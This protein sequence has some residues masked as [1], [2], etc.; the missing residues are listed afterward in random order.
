MST[1][2]RRHRLG[3]DFNLGGEQAEADPLLDRVFVEWTGYQ[4]VES[5]MNPRCFLIGRTGSGKSAVLQRLEEVHPRRVIRINPED[6]S[7]PYIVDLGVIRSLDALNVHLD[8]LFIALWK[9]VPLVEIIRHRYSVDS[10]TKK[11]TVLQSLKDSFSR[12]PS[13]QA[14]LEYLEQF[15]ESFW[16]ETDDRVREITTNF[17]NQVKKLAGVAIDVPLVGEG[18][19]GIEGLTVRRELADRYQ[20]LVNETQLSRLNKMIAVLD[21]EVLSSKQN[22]TYVVVDD[23]DRDWADE[24]LSN[25][26]IR[27][28]F[29]A[30]LDLQ[31]VANLKIVVAL[32]TN[33]FEHLNFG[34]RTGGQEEKFRSLIF[35]IQWTRWE[36]IAMADERARVAAEEAGIPGI[37][38]VADVLPQTGRARGNPM[39][40]ILERT[41]LRPRDVIAFLNECLIGAAGKSRLNWKDIAAAEGRYSQNR[42]LGL[43]DEWKTNYPGIDLAFN[44]FRGAPAEMSQDDLTPY[45]DG[46]ALLMVDHEFEGVRW[47][48]EVA[49]PVWS[50]GAAPE[51]WADSYQPLVKLL[52]D[53]GFLGIGDGGPAI[54]SYEKPGYADAPTNLRDSTRYSVHPTFQPT[55]GVR[56]PVASR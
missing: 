25:D 24:K 11:R 7:L 55:L 33:I 44:L 1:R 21:D 6:L 19:L 35:R 26:L 48:T 34:S 53:I 42:L 41:L 27:C 47:V 38:G 36:L 23:L 32:R 5:P 30:V 56:R 2:Q 13:K 37:N 54:F 18:Q 22:F 17:E 14:A 43:R 39:D 46:I 31:R 45:L 28:L 20:R 50:G 15:G 29:R 16:A 9:H 12:D 3:S 52:Y 10:P 40:Y 4:A 8:P 49:E 51:A